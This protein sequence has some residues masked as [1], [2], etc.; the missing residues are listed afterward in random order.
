MFFQVWRTAL[1][2][3]SRIAREDKQQKIQKKKENNKLRVGMDVEIKGMKKVGL[4]A[5]NTCRMHARREDTH[6]NVRERQDSLALF[7]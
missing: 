6:A 2:T 4:G 5:T 7:P 3:V 1:H